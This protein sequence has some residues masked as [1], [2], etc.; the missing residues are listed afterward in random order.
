MSKFVKVNPVG[1]KGK[2]CI[3]CGEPVRLTVHEE[4][5]LEYGK[6]IGEKCCDKCKAAILHM[7]KQLEEIEK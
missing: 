1:Y 2:S 3:V 5:A 7:R 4:M 6:H